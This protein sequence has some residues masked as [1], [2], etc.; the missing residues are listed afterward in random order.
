MERLELLLLPPLRLFSLLHLSLSLD[1]L[2]LVTIVAVISVPLLA[3][4]V[5]SSP[6]I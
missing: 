5:D 2:Q 4:I 6:S 1:Y 3:V